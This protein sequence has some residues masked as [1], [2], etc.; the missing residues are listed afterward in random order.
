MARLGVLGLV[1]WATTASAQTSKFGVRIT[2]SG[3]DAVAA[4]VVY[5]LKE[6]VAKSARFEVVKPKGS[7]AEISIVSLDLD[8]DKPVGLASA[9]SVQYTVWAKCTTPKTAT[10][11]EQVW[12]ETFNTHSLL[13]VGRNHA[14]AKGT[15]ILAEFS[16][17]KDNVESSYPQCTP[18]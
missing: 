2:H 18:L 16:S 14:A 8:T 7:E 4:Q 9:M 6:A 10:K 11:P 1:L 3:T 12:I 15:E 17:Y 13:I 5:H